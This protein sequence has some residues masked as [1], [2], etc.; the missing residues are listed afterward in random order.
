MW[1][2]RGTVETKAPF[3]AG[4]LIL[5]FLTLEIFVYYDIK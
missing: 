4:K 5:F 1:N 2:V 3:R